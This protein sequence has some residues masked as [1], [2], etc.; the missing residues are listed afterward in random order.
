MSCFR[1]CQ[2]CFLPYSLGKNHNV[3][4][5]VTKILLAVQGLQDATEATCH[6]AHQLIGRVPHLLYN[7]TS[8]VQ[9]ANSRGK[10]RVVA[11]F[12]LT[13]ALIA[14]AQQI[15]IPETVL[16]GAIPRPD[17]FN[18]T[19]VRTRTLFLHSC[20]SGDEDDSADC[21]PSAL[22]AVQD[23]SLS[24]YQVWQMDNSIDEIAIGT[25]SSAVLHS[26][27]GMSLLTI[28]CFLL[29]N[30]I[31]SC[32]EGSKLGVKPMMEAFGF[33]WGWKDY[34]ASPILS[35]TNGSGTLL[36]AQCHSFS[37]QNIASSMS[38]PNLCGSPDMTTP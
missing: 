20:T 37:L 25:I 17:I 3:R 10:R 36:S 27:Q 6:A 4:P 24:S 15:E 7:D 28:L 22:H 23:L 38:L 9:A 26:V 21:F 8:A 29:A 12:T 32:A 14:A 31:A 1:Y 2:T 13:R 34:V 5:L 30:K 19:V 33:A 18:R 16:A 35:P 11:D